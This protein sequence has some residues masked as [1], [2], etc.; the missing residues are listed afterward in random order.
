M[1]FY[2]IWHPHCYFIVNAAVLEIG[3]AWIIW[4][5]EGKK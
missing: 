3:P 2:R 1:L 4:W 5:R